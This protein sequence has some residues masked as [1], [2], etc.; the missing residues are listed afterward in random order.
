[1]FGFLFLNWYIYPNRNGK[2]NRKYPYVI[3]KYKT[4]KNNYFFAIHLLFMNVILFSYVI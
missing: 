1:M 3:S 2:A 4:M